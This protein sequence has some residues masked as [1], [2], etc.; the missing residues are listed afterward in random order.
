MKLAENDVKDWLTR[1]ETTLASACPD[2]FFLEKK[3]IK[4]TSTIIAEKK[5]TVLQDAIV[6]RLV[7][8]GKT[9]DVNTGA[10]AGG[11]NIKRIASGIW[12]IHVNGKGKILMSVQKDG[13]FR[14]YCAGH[15]QDIEDEM[16][17][18]RLI[19]PSGNP[20]VPAYKEYK[21]IYPKPYVKK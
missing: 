7:N 18:F 10:D 12:D 3:Q 19:D 6:E 4:N 21:A 8:V 15:S 16:N 9:H 11:N 1:L 2:L 17:S 14:V 20:S 13:R 5:Q